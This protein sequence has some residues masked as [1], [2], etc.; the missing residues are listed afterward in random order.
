M[1]RFLV[2]RVAHCGDGCRRCPPGQNIKCPG[3]HFFVC[4]RLKVYSIIKPLPDSGKNNKLSV[5]LRRD[6]EFSARHSEQ[7]HPEEEF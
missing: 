5:K 6:F 7:V 1:V 2:P 3:G 4:H